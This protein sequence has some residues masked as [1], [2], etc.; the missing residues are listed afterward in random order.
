MREQFS[1]EALPGRVVFGAGT[2]RTALAD[3]VARLGAA[4]VLLIATEQ[5]EPLARE[6]TTPFA[7]RIAA[8]FTAVR[9]HVPTEGKESILVDRSASVAGPPPVRRRR[10][11]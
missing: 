5:E 11:L 8:I 3:E 2:A 4:R 6:L 1:Y 10:S 7:E 9:P